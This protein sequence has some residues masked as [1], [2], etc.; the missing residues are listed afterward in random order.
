[1]ADR[2]EWPVGEI[3]RSSIVFVLISKARRVLNVTL[4]R[5]ALPR[6]A[7]AIGAAISRTTGM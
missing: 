4:L 1:M 3:G 2:R 7:G 5:I 6:I